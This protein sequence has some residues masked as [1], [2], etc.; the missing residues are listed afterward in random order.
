M[1]S[2]AHPPQ[3]RHAGRHR[4]FTLVEVMVTVAVIAILSAIALPMYTSY[5]ERSNVQQ[6]LQRLA[7]A[8]TRMEQFFM[9]N[10]TYLKSGTC[11]VDVAA[12]TPATDKFGLSCTDVS[13]TAYT[14]T[15]TGRGSMTGFTYTIDQTSTGTSTITKAGWETGG[16]VFCW[17]TKPKESCS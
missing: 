6:G 17:V 13:A 12:L 10:R 5:V 9:D 7:E 3:S 8:R 14:I 15:A 2:P 11:G 4:G 1:S 16:K